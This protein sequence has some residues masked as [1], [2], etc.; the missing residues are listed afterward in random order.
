MKVAIIGSG[1]VGAS[2]AQRIAE[3]DLADVV[4]L[5][6]LEGRAQARA[7]DLNSASSIVR[8]SR[9]VT[10][11]NNYEDIAGAQ[12][13]VVTA[14]QTRSPGQ[15]RED[16]L[17]N[18]A[19]IIKSVCKEI[20]KHCV[21]AVV[22]IVSNP[23]DVMSYLAYKTTG[24]AKNQIIGMGGTSD[25]ARF[26]MLA[27]E[28]LNTASLYVQS[29][30]IGAHGNSMVVLPRLSTILG[31]PL[32]ELLPKNRIKRI[33]KETGSF[34]A[35]IVKL[36]GKG[37]AHYGPSAGVFVL[38]DAIINDRKNILCASAYMSNQY[39]LDDLFIGV[40]TKVGRMGIEEVI[41]LKLTKEEK[42]KFLDSA[43]GV[44]ELINKLGVL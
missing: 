4:L 17:N 7:L 18:N 35:K 21:G 40:P 31:I 1:D 20:A 14:G 37:S 16:L 27:A 28:E 33:V 34:G 12:V 9:T 2:C 42:V 44:K 23:V 41:E 39:D 43:K 36:L 11:T 32:T 8:H 19:K 6:I 15:T 22:I 29:V 38:V 3:A 13:V 30:I 24:F 25:C 10:G 5:D 26:N